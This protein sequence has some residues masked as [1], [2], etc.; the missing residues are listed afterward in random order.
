VWGTIYAIYIGLLPAELEAKAAEAVSKAYLEDQIAVHGYV[1][2]I[3]TVDDDEFGQSWEA[4]NVIH[5][6]PDN[7]QN[8]GYWGSASGWLFYALAKADI[9]LAEKCIE[10]FV[11][12]TEKYRAE[13]A[14][15][16]FINRACTYWEGK[17]AGTCATLPYAGAKR[18]IDELC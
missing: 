14:P 1:R 16:E 4:P 11:M 9:K 5:T 18:I 3:R 2:M 17:L 13:G 8:G 7:Y 10:E 15:F 6:K 12:H